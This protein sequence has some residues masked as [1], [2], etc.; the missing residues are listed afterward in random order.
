VEESTLKDKYPR[1][2][3]IFTNPTA[4]HKKGFM[5]IRQTLMDGQDIVVD[6]ARFRKVLLQ[7]LN[8]HLTQ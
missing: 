1:D 3:M 6:V 4:L 8:N 5:F 7:I 2:H